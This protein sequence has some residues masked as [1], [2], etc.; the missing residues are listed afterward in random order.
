M[1]KSKVELFR[2]TCRIIGSMEIVIVEAKISLLFVMHHSK[3]IDVRDAEGLNL[4]PMTMIRQAHKWIT[5]IEEGSYARAKKA[6]A[7]L[8]PDVWER[9]KTWGW[10]LLEDSR[11]AKI[12]KEALKAFKK[13]FM[14]M[15]TRPDFF[16][17]GKLYAEARKKGYKAAK[18]E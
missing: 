1:S 5:R 10:D 12:I 7:L 6:L 11:E 8:P 18:K 17:K 14:D 16:K 15:K 2:E 9:Y 4:F 13:D 3:Y